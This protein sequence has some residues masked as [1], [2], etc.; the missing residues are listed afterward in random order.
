MKKLIKE[1]IHLIKSLIS[2]QLGNVITEQEIY[3]GGGDPYSYKIVDGEW[4]AKG[5]RIPEWKSLKGNSKAYASLNRRFPDALG[6]PSTPKTTKPSPELKGLGDT[7]FKTTDEGNKFRTWV[8]EDKGRYY[9]V[10][11]A[12]IDFGITEKDGSTPRLSSRGAINNNHMKVAYSVLG[13]TYGKPTKPDEP[14]TKPTQ[15][16]ID[17]LV[18][19]KNSMYI[20]EGEMKQILSI[21]KK[22]QKQ[23]KICKLIADYS[24][25]NPTGIAKFLESIKEKGWMGGEHDTYRKQSIDLIASTTC[26]GEKGDIEVADDISVDFK[27]K[28][29]FDNLSTTDT[30]NKV[31][32]PNDPHCAQFVNDYSEDI[33]SVGNAWH[34]YRN[35]NNLGP[36]IFNRFTN[37]SSTDSK[38]LEDLWVKIHKNK[39]GKTSGRFNS[40]ARDF[41][42][43]LVPQG[44]VNMKLQPN[45]VVGLYF[46]PSSHHEE[47]LY[48]GGRNWFTNPQGQQKPKFGE[49][50][51]AGNNLKKGNAWGMN[52][53]VGIVGAL[54]D[55]VPLV[56]HN[57]TG[58]V[59]SDPINNLNVAWIK[60]P[61]A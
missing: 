43:S 5:P 6:K 59:K 45:D 55:G 49:E 57:V 50:A 3:K 46:K 2:Y 1:D 32:K 36:T 12:L 15:G 44:G 37:L 41:V 11:K 9:K 21:L 31:C 25:Q 42:G 22:W 52:T 60:R 58:N 4:W 13:D 28:I 34:A 39:G 16:D 20:G 23:G 35:T 61:P 48:H 18:S 14:T 19:Q 8:R 30:T 7:P 40:E 56:F 10:K 51:I 54:K 24:T 33:K 17:Y 26:T 29:D 27:D 53:H 38:T 47:A